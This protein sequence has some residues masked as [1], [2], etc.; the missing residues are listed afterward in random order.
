MGSSGLLAGSPGERT[1]ALHVLSWKHTMAQVSSDR[2]AS[3]SAPGK[4]PLSARQTRVSP[5]EALVADARA[6]LTPAQMVERKVAVLLKDQAQPI[7]GMKTARRTSRS[8]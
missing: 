2:Y 1:I 7:S 8:H 3:D 4:P 5:E 6:G